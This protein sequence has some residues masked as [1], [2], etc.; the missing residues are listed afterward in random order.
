[1]VKKLK[2][3]II[4]FGIIVILFLVVIPQNIPARKDVKNAQQKEYHS[5]KSSDFKNVYVEI[6][7][8][9]RYINIRIGLFGFYFYIRVI[10]LIYHPGMEP[11]ECR[12][13]LKIYEN[14]ELV[15]NEDYFDFEVNLIFF[16]GTITLFPIFDNNGGEIQ[17]TTH[18]IRWSGVPS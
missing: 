13:N 12:G 18:E 3:K 5:Y 16:K 1:M 17:G 10:P 8:Y 4:L 14:G 9:G 15:F 2:N 7:F 11:D 6:A